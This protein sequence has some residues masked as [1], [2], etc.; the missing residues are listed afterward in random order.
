MP[1]HFD[2]KKYRGDISIFIETG[3]YYGDGIL[4]ALEA[5]FTTIYSIE[6]D[7][8]RYKH[9][10]LQFQE[11][12]NVHL[13]HGDSSIELPN[14]LHTLKEEA[15]FWLDAHY[16]A[17]GATLGNKWTPIEEELNAIK[18]HKIKSHTI[19]IDDFR[20]FNNR[21]IDEATQI[22]VGFLGQENCIQFL[23]SINKE[24]KMEFEKGF[25]D[26]DVLLCYLAR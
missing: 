2:L 24:Y 13:I 17:D 19:A 6:L 22:P 10:V 23:K 3:S 1:I 7:E 21:H 15:F 16:C 26:K 14:L 5:G 4:K 8:K 11:K 25:I 12:K 18:N 9:C 20:C